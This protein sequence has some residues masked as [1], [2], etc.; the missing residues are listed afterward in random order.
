MKKMTSRREFLKMSGLCLVALPLSGTLTSFTSAG[1]GSKKQKHPSKESAPS[2]KSISLSVKDSGAVGDGRTKD[3]AAIQQTIDRCHVLGGGEVLV[4]AGQYLTGALQLRSNITLRLEKDAVLLGTPDFADYPVSQV[5]WEGKW[6]QGH[7]ALI[8]AVDAENIGIKGP[9]K[10]A[11]NYALGGRP[12]S[13]DP[14]RHPALIEPIRCK[15]IVFEDFSTDYHSMWCLHPTY[16]ENILC[17]NLFIR[18]TG[19]NGDG[20]DVDSCKHV[21]IEGCDIETGDDCIAIKSGRGMEANRI[22]WSTEDVHISNCKFSDT[23]YACIGIGS[24]TSGGIRDVRI[25]HCTFVNTKTY[26]LYIKSRPGRGAFIENI[27]ADNLDVSGMQGGFLRFNILGSGI[28]DQ[29][30]VPGLDGIPTLKNFSFTNV[31]VNDVP[32]LVDGT[33]IHPEKPLDGFTLENVSGTCKQGIR[34]ANI[35]HASIKNVTVSGFEG[36]LLGICHVHGKGFENAENI[37]FPHELGAAIQPPVPPYEL[38]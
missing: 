20:I 25:E 22:G 3:T 23:I 27:S 24:E 34:L 32:I 7:T 5:R 9:G 4:P 31:R 16:C 36:P 14:L 13:A 19:G 30:P 26:A 29:V 6:I 2:L 37:A 11:G 12:S 38:K 17:K 10:I 15:N 21:V 18:S 33:S 28:Q 35:E 8:Y 1:T